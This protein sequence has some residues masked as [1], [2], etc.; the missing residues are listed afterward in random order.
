MSLS[1]DP[2]RPYLPVAW[3]L[4]AA[5]LL[6]G[7]CSWGKNQERNAI[8]KQMARKDQALRDAGASLKAA[9]EALK[10][11]DAANKTRIAEARRAGEL[12]GKAQ[13]MAD[14]QAKAGERAAAAYAKGLR[15]AAR[16]RPACDALLKSDVL[17]T[18]GL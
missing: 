5:V 12:A 13:A 7:G 9:G 2:I 4:L 10:A 15:E 6:F 11:Q 17:R 1:I 14:A 16:Q 8:A 3:L 18:C